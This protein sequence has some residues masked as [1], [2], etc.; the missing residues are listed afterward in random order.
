[1][2]IL[3]LCAMVLFLPKAFRGR[4]ERVKPPVA[5]RSLLKKQ[6]LSGGTLR[7]GEFLV[8]SYKIKAHEIPQVEMDH[9]GDSCA[10][11]IELVKMQAG[12]QPK[13]R[14]RPSSKLVRPSKRY[15]LQDEAFEDVKVEDLQDEAFEDVK[16]EDLQDEAFEDVKV[17]DLQD[18][19]FEDVKVE[20]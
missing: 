8:R 15:D 3:L 11:W 17:E 13:S 10:S 4:E 16:V 2:T 14:A 6:K 7:C 20:D 12:C 1:M 18:E 5:P 19:A 9:D